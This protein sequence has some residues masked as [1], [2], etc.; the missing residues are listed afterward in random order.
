MTYYI[1]VNSVVI[2]KKT[3]TSFLVNY[4]KLE[5]SKD[6]LT[7]IEI[8]EKLNETF[9]LPS[10]KWCKCFDNMFNVSIYSSSEL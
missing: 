2:K 7:T 1:N 6:D 8:F 5:T 9:F 3:I 4:R 10:S